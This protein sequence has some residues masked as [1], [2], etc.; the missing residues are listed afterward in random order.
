MDAVV[1]MAFSDG[2]KLLRKAQ[3]ENWLRVDKLFRELEADQRLIQE[4]IERDG[5][6]D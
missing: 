4:R 3:L 2:L 1:Q 5:R 6:D